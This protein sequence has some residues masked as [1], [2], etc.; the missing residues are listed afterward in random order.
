MKKYKGVSA[1]LKKSI[2]DIYIGVGVKRALCPL[3]GIK[4]IN[5]N[6]NAGFEAAH[7]VAD[8]YFYEEVSVLYFYPSCDVCNNDCADLCILDFLWL[9]ARFAKLKE[10][11]FA[12]YH[13]F[14]SMHEG[15]L[16]NTMAP[17]ILDFLYGPDR[18]KAGGGI[19]NR[20]QIYEIARIVQYNELREK[21]AE[22]NR[23]VQKLG[24]EM[25]ELLNYEI[26]TLMF[27]YTV[28]LTFKLCQSSSANFCASGVNILAP[29]PLVNVNNVVNTSD[30]VKLLVM[31]LH[32]FCV[33][34]GAIQSHH[35]R[36]N[37]TLRQILEIIQT[38]VSPCGTIL[39]SI[40]RI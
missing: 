17:S 26:K 19:Q 11:I 23:Q 9:R 15:D 33:I 28:I 8:K 40:A 14:I 3:C 7:V 24:K 13:A 10:M 6:T 18:F 20:K 37:T 29:M 16:A 21:S 5:A 2:W 30:R 12:I 38:V 32:A 31:S 35:R 1:S 36:S 39:Q 27:A 22:L 4:Y 34:M 25:E